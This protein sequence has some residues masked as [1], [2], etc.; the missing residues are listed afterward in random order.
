MPKPDPTSEPSA[1]TLAD[2]SALADGT[3]APER[4]PAVREL[5]ARSPE[6]SERY[7]RERY[8]VSALRGTRSDF[9]PP[10][11]R[12]RIEG[13]R[14]KVRQRP[15]LVYGGALGA[16]VAAVAVAVILLLPGGAPGSPSVSQAAALALRGPVLGAPMP[17]RKHPGANLRQDVEEVYFPD[18]SRWFGWTATG[19]RSDRLDGRRAVTVY[20]KHATTQIA[21]TILAAPALPWPRTQTRWFEGTK[22]QSFRLGGRVVVTWRRAGHTCVLSGSGLST[23]QLAQL[24]AR[25]MPGGA[26]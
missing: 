8:A 22:L 18:W 16:A 14:R 12:A 9:P 3:L 20:Y 24:A 23:Q 21:Y 6:L 11:L 4:V 26:A 2:V 7:E 19:Q 10:R 25:K 1:R 17:D 15:R 13:Q 5:I